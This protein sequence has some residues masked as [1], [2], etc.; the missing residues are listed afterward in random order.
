MLT[1]DAEENSVETTD[2]YLL[3]MLNKARKLNIQMKTIVLQVIKISAAWNQ[4][5]LQQSVAGR[6][7]F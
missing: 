4:Y 7:F 6:I 1:Q 5:Y 3:K 2:S